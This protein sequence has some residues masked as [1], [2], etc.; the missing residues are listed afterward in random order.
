MRQAEWHRYEEKESSGEFGRH[1]AGLVLR[2]VV[3]CWFIINLQGN[4]VC[5]LKR[6]SETT[7]T[8]EGF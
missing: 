1:R 5:L 3:S 4:S 6:G 2:L 8:L 7:Y